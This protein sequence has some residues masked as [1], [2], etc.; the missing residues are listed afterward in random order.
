MGGSKYAKG[1]K[2]LGTLEAVEEIMNGRCLWERGK[3]QNPGWTQNYSVHQISRLV[4]RGVLYKAVK[5]R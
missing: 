4:A 2:I 3:V 1:E 5:V